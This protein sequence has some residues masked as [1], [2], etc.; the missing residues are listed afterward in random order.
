MEEIFLNNKSIKAVGEI[1]LDF[2]Y[3]KETKQYQY[4][5]LEKQLFLSEKF[6][7]PV[8]LHCRDAEQELFDILNGFKGVEG[9][10][11]CFSSTKDWCEKFIDLG[12]YVSFSG[13]VTFKNANDIRSAAKWMPLDRMLVE[14]DCPYL[15]PQGHRGKT[16]EPSFIVNTIEAIAKLRD[17]TFD[18]IAEKTY[19]NTLILFK[20]EDS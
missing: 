18:D 19:K 5:L 9:V 14:T 1:G 4:S 6:N 20:I 15:A 13:I 3:G 8:I 7:L 2:Y 16:N 11:H 10:I 17:L 12:F